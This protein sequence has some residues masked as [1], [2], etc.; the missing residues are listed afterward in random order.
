MFIMVIFDYMKIQ[1]LV[2]VDIL[3]NEVK[4]V[5]D[6]ICEQFDVMFNVV[7]GQDVFGI[8]EEVELL[9]ND[10]IDVVIGSDGVV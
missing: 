4:F 9:V 3:G 5:V 1:M 6:V 10:V 7:N 8:L 2:C